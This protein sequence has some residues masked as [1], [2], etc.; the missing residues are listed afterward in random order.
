MQNCHGSLMASGI[1]G[2]LSNGLASVMSL[3]ATC[4]TGSMA[5]WLI[6]SNER[7]AFGQVYFIKIDNLDYP[8]RP[9]DLSWLNRLDCKERRDGENKLRGSNHNKSRWHC[10]CFYFEAIMTET[11]AHRW[12]HIKERFYTAESL[13]I[14]TFANFTN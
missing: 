5:T 8:N 14:I 13:E 10:C 4:L 3:H 2:E 7:P 6:D 11:K 12:I 1:Y 9:L